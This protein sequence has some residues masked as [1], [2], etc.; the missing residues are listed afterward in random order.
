MSSSITGKMERSNGEAFGTLFTD[1]PKAFE[2]FDLELLIAKL[3]A[4]DF[5]LKL[6]FSFSEW[7]EI[8]F[9]ST[10]R[11]NFGSASIRNVFDRP[12]LF[13]GPHICS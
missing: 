5:S 8:I 6:R 1:L 4:Y 12:L 2:C 3:N 13:H 11:F 7:L 10:T 9:L